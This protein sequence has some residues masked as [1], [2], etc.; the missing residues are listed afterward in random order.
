MNWNSNVLAFVVL[1][2]V[3][4]R[5]VERIKIRKTAYCL[6]S[7]EPTIELCRRIICFEH[8]R[9]E[10]EQTLIDFHESCSTTSRFIH[11]Q[12]ETVCDNDDCVQ[13]SRTVVRF[14]AERVLYCV[15]TSGATGATLCAC[16]GLVYAEQGWAW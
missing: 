7:R 16:F 11:S 14:A 15:L 1:L 12:G 9:Y 2:T 3:V 5:R 4:V 6:L 10:V 13:S 8:V